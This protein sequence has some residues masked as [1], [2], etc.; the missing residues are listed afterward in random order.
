MILI[1]FIIYEEWYVRV[2]ICKGLYRIIYTGIK[3]RR[4]TKILKSTKLKSNLS[5]MMSFLNR[6]LCAKLD[7]KIDSEWDSHIWSI[8]W[9]HSWIYSILWFIYFSIVFDKIE[10]MA[11]CRYSL[12]EPCFFISLG[13][14]TLHQSVNFW[15]SFIALEDFQICYPFTNI[16]INFRVSTRRLK[17]K[18]F[19][20]AN[21]RPAPQSERI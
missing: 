8:I 21:K 12:P 3:R 10:V 7:I 19:W 5:R 4:Q 11:I 20:N 13:L 15:I 16:Q 6:T 2:V 1:K 18:H 9:S 14:A 17:K